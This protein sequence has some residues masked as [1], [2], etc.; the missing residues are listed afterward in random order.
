MIRCL[1]DE[2]ILGTG[3]MIIAKGKNP[4]LVSQIFIAFEALL[5]G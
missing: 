4:T 2:E 5:P 1:K 3:D